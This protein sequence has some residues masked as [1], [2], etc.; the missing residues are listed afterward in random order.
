MEGRT[1]VSTLFGR[2]GPLLGQTRR[3]APTPGSA[4]ACIVYFVTGPKGLADELEDDLAQVRKG[5]D[6][7]LVSVC[8][9]GGLS[10]PRA[11]RMIP[12]YFQIIGEY[13]E[14]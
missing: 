6:A 2:T 12:L 3:S 4:V 14:K 9:K 8:P 5:N 1:H 11:R 10:S 7:R 13:S